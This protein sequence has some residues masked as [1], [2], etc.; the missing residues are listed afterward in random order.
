MFGLASAITVHGIRI[1]WIC[2]ICKE[3]QPYANCAGK[4]RLYLLTSSL[5]LLATR[6]LVLVVV[7]VHLRVIFN[8]EQDCLFH[9]T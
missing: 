1:C 2:A 8:L 4:P 7:Y 5:E 3:Q 6:L 9:D